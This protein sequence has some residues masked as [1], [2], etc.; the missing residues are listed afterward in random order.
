MLFHHSLFDHLLWSF[1]R[2]CQVVLAAIGCGFGTRFLDPQQAL[3]TKPLGAGSPTV[4]G[5]KG[6]PGSLLFLVPGCFNLKSCQVLSLVMLKIAE[7][8]T[9]CVLV[10]T[11]WGKPGMFLG[12]RTQE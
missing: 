5:T 10:T 3:C 1:G 7:V 4:V 12:K 6:F 11:S 8:C 2:R 9:S